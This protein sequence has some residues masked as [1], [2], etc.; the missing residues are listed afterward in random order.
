MNDIIMDPADSM[1]GRVMDLITGQESSET[2]T[3]QSD[4]G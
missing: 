2:E 3:E 4:N 1:L